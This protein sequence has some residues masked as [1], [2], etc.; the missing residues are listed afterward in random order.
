MPSRPVV[1]GQFH[2]ICILTLKTSPEK[3]YSMQHAAPVED[4]VLGVGVQDIA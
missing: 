4:V 1:E 2:H 3:L